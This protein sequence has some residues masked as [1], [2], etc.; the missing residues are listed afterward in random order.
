MNEI[1]KEYSYFKSQDKIVLSDVLQIIF[2]I[3]FLN[4][5]YFNGMSV[6]Y[7][8]ILLPIFY[9]LKNNTLIRPNNLISFFFILCFLVFITSTVSMHESQFP[10][11]RVLSFIIILSLASFVLIPLNHKIIQNFA[12]ALTILSALLTIQLLYKLISYGE[13][14]NVLKLKGEI[15][16]QRR[17]MIH[18]MAF[19]WLLSQFLFEKKSKLIKCALIIFI[20]LSF[21][22]IML[23]FTR[24]GILAVLLT[25]LALCFRHINFRYL[26]KIH[27]LFYL[28]ILLIF[29][30]FFADYL[31]LFYSFFKLTFLD[32]LGSGQLS[33]NFLNKD[34]SSEGTRAQIW[35]EI[36]NYVL[37]N[38][39]WGS[40][41][42]GY[43]ILS[44]DL[45]GS[46]HSDYF[47]RLLRF[48]IPLFFLYACILIRILNYLRHNFSGFY[49]G[50][51]SILI[52]GIFHEA[53][54]ISSG[55]VIL[56]F[57]M[58]LYSQRKSL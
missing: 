36:L 24:S 46:S 55:A 8:L 51:V 42:L 47:D 6:N 1:Y 29:Y 2:F 10:I 9:G 28:I 33:T 20:F 49:Y 58:G 53:F 57:L 39:F 18:L 34:N 11:R 5:I 38:P 14:S 25:L 30:N 56:S 21:S 27:N 16:G 48:G 4:P 32:Q 3:F 13:L 41:F 40:G 52:F 37:K 44:P 22:G 31:D 43:W 17:V 45:I 54:A 7:F 12:Y 23:S 50:Y 35:I 19:F 26:F 15:G